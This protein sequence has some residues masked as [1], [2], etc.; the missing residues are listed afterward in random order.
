MPPAGRTLPSAT[1]RAGQVAEARIASLAARLDG[2]DLEVTS[3]P[4]A[5]TSSAPAGSLA[6]STGQQRQLESR[7][8]YGTRRRMN[9]FF[10]KWMDRVLGRCALECRVEPAEDRVAFVIGVFPLCDRLY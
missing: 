10:L 1:R 2:I 6:L 7:P 8:P 4:I 5:V 9:W 3:R